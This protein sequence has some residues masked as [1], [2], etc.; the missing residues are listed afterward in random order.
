MAVLVRAQKYV[1]DPA[2]AQEVLD[3]VAAQTK[4]DRALV[5]AIWGD[6]SFNPAFDDAYVAD[7]E[8]MSRY[9]VA[10]GRVRAPKHPLDYTF[11]DPVAA[12]D[13]SLVKLPGRWKA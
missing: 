8:S 4:Q 10:S 11:T 13:A 1:A 5:A 12:A 7:M 3:L 2:N 9:L 6:Y